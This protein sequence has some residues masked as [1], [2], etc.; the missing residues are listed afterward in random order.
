MHRTERS[1]ENLE[2]KVE[3]FSLVQVLI[4]G[5]RLQLTLLL[6]L[7]LVALNMETIKNE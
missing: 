6:L 7:F 3:K 2:N 5:Q 4:D 1:E